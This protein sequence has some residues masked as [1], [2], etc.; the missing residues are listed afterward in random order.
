MT[1]ATHDIQLISEAKPT[2]SSPSRLRQGLKGVSMQQLHSFA[3]D[4]TARLGLK[5]W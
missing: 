4:L 1:I 2:G 5:V 3:I